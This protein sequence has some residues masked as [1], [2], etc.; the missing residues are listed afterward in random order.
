[1][2]RP[3]A[4]WITPESRPR[5]YDT[6][7]FLAACP[8]TQ[9]ADPQTT[10]ATAVCWVGPGAPEAADEGVIQL[11]L[12]TRRCLEELTDL[13]DAPA[14]FQRAEQR[15]IKADIAMITIRDGLEVVRVP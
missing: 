6:N 5:R 11:M 12:P 2:L 4:N 8:S 1:M 15:T 14:A 3:W 9:V 13:A 7:F 10:E